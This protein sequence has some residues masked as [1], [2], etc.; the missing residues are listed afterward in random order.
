MQSIETNT[1]LGA[2]TWEMMK[3]AE[4]HFDFSEPDKAIIE[5]RSHGLHLVLLWCD[6]FKNAMATYAPG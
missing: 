2:V 4:G 6:S 5:A 1:L 3:P